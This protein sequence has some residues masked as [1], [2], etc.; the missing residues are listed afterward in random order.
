[1]AFLDNFSKKI[2]EV[3]QSAVQKTKNMADIVK[4]TTQISEE[5]KKINDMYL[6][7]GKLYVERYAM[8]NADMDINS[9]IETIKASHASIENCKKMIEDLKGVEKCPSCGAEVENDALFCPLCGATV[10]V[11]EAPQQMPAGKICP[12]C[13]AQ[14]PEDSKFCTSCG[15]AFEM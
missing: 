10:K 4:L 5:E 15:H 9:C 7:I 13:N 3:S 12:A 6:Q 1:M 8:N 11:I 2:T 14:V